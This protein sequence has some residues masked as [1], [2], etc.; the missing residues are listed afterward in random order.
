[1]NPTVYAALPPEEQAQQR[2]RL[3]F[4]IFALSGGDHTAK[5][6][7]TDLTL[8]WEHSLTFTFGVIRDLHNR[9][10]AHM[11]MHESVQYVSIQRLCAI[12]MSCALLNPSTP[13]LNPYRLV[14]F[15]VLDQQDVDSVAWSWKMR[16][17]KELHLL[18]VLSALE[19]NGTR[20]SH[21]AREALQP[22]HAT[23][24]ELTSMVARLEEDGMLV[25]TTLNLEVQLTQAGAEFVNEVLR[26]PE[27]TAIHNQVFPSLNDAHAIL[28]RVLI[29]QEKQ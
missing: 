10:E 27:R 12:M 19:R 29:S 8:L 2:E 22:V 20:R 3:L 26:A 16:R 1:M 15:G 7:V 13:G 24:R 25:R 4:Q 17:A 9:G 14:R 18:L 6:R 11:S 23:D 5:F 28:K 21:S